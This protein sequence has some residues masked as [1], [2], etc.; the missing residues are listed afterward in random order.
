MQTLSWGHRTWSIA[1]C[2]ERPGV[3]EDPNHF[4]GGDEAPLVVGRSREE[5]FSALH[6]LQRCFGPHLAADRAGHHVIHHHPDANRGRPIGQGVLDRFD[7]CLFAQCQETGRGQD[8]D[9]TGTDRDRSVGF[10]DDVGDQRGCPGRELARIGCVPGPIWGRRS[11]HPS[12]GTSPLDVIEGRLLSAT[13]V[14]CVIDEPVLNRVLTAALA[15]GTEFAEV[16]AEDA[17]RNSVNLDDGRIENL[18][19]SRDRGAGIRVIA[20]GTVGFAHT[21]DLS[22]ASLVRAARAAAEA[23]RRHAA[24]G[25]GHAVEIA[26]Q[27]SSPAPVEKPPADVDKA[28]KVGAVR[29]ADQVAR[30]YDRA[31]TQVSANYADTRRRI[32]VANSDGLLTTDDQTRTQFSV[33]CVA[34]GDAGMQTGRESVGHTMGYELLDRYSVD[35]LATSAAARA[36]SKL[37]ARPAPS[38]THTVVIGPGS[39]GVLFHE[40]CG[41]GLEADLV[42]KGASTFAGKLGQKVAS[43]LV[44]LIDDG[45]MAGEWGQFA[46]D[47]EGQPAARNVLI[48]NGVLVD[49]LWD[50]IR[51]RQEGRPSSGNGRRQSYK[52]LPMVRMTNTYLAGGQTDPADIIAGVANG[53]YVARLGGGQVNTTSGDFVFGMTEAYLIEDGKI[54]T[55][56]REGQLI[57]NGPKVLQMI[58]AVGNDFEMGPPGTCGKDGQGV[59]VGDGVPTLRVTEM[60]IGGTAA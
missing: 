18:A 36:V 23:A 45:T 15:D 6:L 32:L 26:T 29:R 22:E 53:V 60:T 46:V 13:I 40:A 2:Q 8:R 12:H 55:P 58:D 47:D 39:G 21:A 11:G 35:E 19:S 49:Y 52:H 20:H 9:R 14:G 38:G 51:A 34:T 54:T 44:T 37:E 10:G 24:P 42:R 27:S 43:E 56:L 31:I 30:A 28:T 1:L 4:A 5:Q 41:H 48:E 33:S 3:D 57:G 25:S 7:R 16:F 59:P 17:E 50:G